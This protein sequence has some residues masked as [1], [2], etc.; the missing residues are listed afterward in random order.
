MKLSIFAFPA[1]FIATLLMLTATGFFNTYVSLYLDK[2]NVSTILIGANIACYYFGMVLGAKIGQLL[3]AFFGHIRTFVACAGICTIVILAHI[4]IQHIYLWMGFRFILGM[5]MMAQY[6]VIESWLNEQSDSKNRGA[7]FSGYMIAVNMGL[8][9]GQYFLRYLPEL[10]ITQLV[11]VAMLFAGSLIP[12]ATTRKIHPNAIIVAPLEIRY[13]LKT[14]TP[15]LLT[16]AVGGML[17]GSFFGLAPIYAQSAGFSVN[18]SSQF[19]AVAIIAGFLVQWPMG[20]LSDRVN[21]TKLI[22]VNACL[23]AFLS[24][25]LWF[26][27]Y[28]SEIILLVIIFAVGVFLF[29]LYPI[30]VALA[31]DNIASTKRVALSGLLLAIFGVGAGIGPIASGIVMDYFSAKALFV[32][33]FVMGLALFGLLFILKSNPCEEIEEGIEKTAHVPEYPMSSA[34]LDPRIE[35]ETVPDEAK[36]ILDHIEPRETEVPTSIDE[37]SSKQMLSDSNTDAENSQF[38]DESG[39]L[40]NDKKHE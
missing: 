14:T 38:T 23:L 5:A 24:I 21:R 37:Q 7:V 3:I 6:M 17:V 1:L 9:L 16:V 36:I 30:A 33:F 29:T 8:I 35:P 10:S 15:A 26:G 32:V 13:F 19:I 12:V 22:Q 28:W 31:N 39:E 34:I 40:K 20:W 2:L 18:D 27:A 11:I 25:P 4:L